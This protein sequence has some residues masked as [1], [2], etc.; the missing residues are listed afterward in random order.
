M[1][2]TEIMTASFKSCL[3]QPYVFKLGAAIAQKIGRHMFSVPDRD[4][5][6]FLLDSQEKTLLGSAVNSNFNFPTL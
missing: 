5:W 1:L 3:L 6:F 2:L 4:F